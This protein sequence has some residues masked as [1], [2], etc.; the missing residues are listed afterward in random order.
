MSFPYEKDTVDEFLASVD[1]VAEFEEFVAKKTKEK[2]SSPIG[3]R[4]FRWNGNLSGR[5][6]ECSGNSFND[7]TDVI[8]YLNGR[9][10]D[11]KVRFKVYDK[12]SLMTF[13]DRNERGT[14]LYLSLIHI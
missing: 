4:A 9:G 8:S 1:M 10:P 13:P 7:D 12:N 3:N 5:C 11:V 14:L 2:K 6:Y